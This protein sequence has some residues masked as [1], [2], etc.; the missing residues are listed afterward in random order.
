MIKIVDTCSNNNN[1]NNNN[2]N[3]IKNNEYKSYN[4]I[5]IINPSISIED[6]AVSISLK[7]LS[8]NIIIVIGLWLISYTLIIIQII[9]NH[10]IKFIS[11]LFIP[12]IIGTIYGILSI[13]LITKKLFNSLTLQTEERRE[14]LEQHNNNDTNNMIDYHSLPLLRRLLFCNLLLF[15]F[16]ISVLI[17]QILMYIYFV[18]TNYISILQAM[19]PVILYT[20]LF[21][22]YMFIIDTLS[23]NSVFIILLIVV[24]LVLFTIKCQY[25]DNFV[26]N[27][28]DFG[29]FMV[30]TPVFI[31]EVLLLKHLTN[32]YTLFRNNS[33]LLSSI[34]VNCFFI[35]FFSIIMM[36]IGEIIIIILP[37]QTLLTNYLFLISIPTFI[38]SLLNILNC[39]I[40]NLAIT[41]G[42]TNASNPVRDEHGNWVIYPNQT[43]SLLLGT[44]KIHTQ[45][46]SDIVIII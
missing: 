16:L 22:S 18:Y 15:L 3:T 40:Q 29:W 19:I 13:I 39:E 42:E 46:N 33:V 27:S 41:R 43:T 45:T 26:F 36:I 7:H 31:A 9:D 2:N 21:L 5:D 14:Y 20:F 24:G 12:M 37:S 34:Q 44:I 10:F 8:L 32:I 23:I 38:C 6:D 28:Y 17:T 4:S 1:N 30:I 11:Y 25:I 35:F